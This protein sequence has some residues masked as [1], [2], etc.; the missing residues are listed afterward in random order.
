[1]GKADDLLK[2]M[3]GKILESASHRGTPAAM[4]TMN[5]GSLAGGERMAGVARSKSALEIPVERIERDPSQP[6]EEFDEDSLARL[7]ESIKSK[8]LL[9]PISVRW[10]D[11]LSRYVII[12]GERRWRAARMA[13][14][15]TISCVVLDRPLTS[16]ELLALQCIENLVREDLKPIEEARAFRT[17]LTVNNW[18]GNQLAKEL[19][20]SQSAVVQALSLLELPEPIQEQV[21]AGA[22]AASTAYAISKVDDT[23][24]QIEIANR[25]ITDR[26]SRDETAKV[27]KQ[28]VEQKA[29][30]RPSAARSRGKARPK[31]PTERSIKTMSGLK[32]T[33][34]SRK[35]FDAATLL[36]ALE[37]AVSRIQAEVENL[38]Q[39]A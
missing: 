11:E 28:A 7:S 36:A 5:A 10:S 12:A 22:L 29:A 15:T 30:S 24:S 1:M 25:V 35:G 4:P 17:L 13:G 2:S 6:R 33:V 20:I 37:E 34:E 9:Q 31:L 38:E 14:L 8:G 3:G 26:L 39:A 19:G 23:D 21:D 32:I 18:S 16:S 27:V